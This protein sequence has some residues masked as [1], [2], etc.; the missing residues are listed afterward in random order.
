MKQFYTSINC[1]DLVFDV[2]FHPKEDIICAGLI[3]GHLEIYKLL[4]EKRKFKKKHSIECHTDAI[5]CIEF[6]KKGDTVLTGSTD[7]HCSI[8]DIN[9]NILWKQKCHKERITSVLFTSKNTFVSADEKGIMKH[10]DIRSN[11]K[12]PIY[13]IIEFNDYVSSL[14]FCQNTNSIIA[15]SSE[16]LGVFDLIQKKKLSLNAMSDPMEDELLCSSFVRNN[17]KLICGTIGGFLI[18]FSKD[19]WGNFNDRIKVCKDSISSIVKINETVVCVGT[20][21][22]S[23]K[24]VS[25][26]PNK[27]KNDIGRHNDNDSIE[28]IT[29]NKSKDLIASIALDNYIHFYPLYIKESNVTNRIKKNQKSFFHDL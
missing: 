20:G 27:I 4:E 26:F 8:I 3:N 5:R 9:G 25:L 1:D 2:Q 7:K 11:S 21:N 16:Y 22:G 28:K 24:T 10:W 19:Y 18:I 13:E 12:K 17:S 6:S 15:T 14:S 23:I 29:I